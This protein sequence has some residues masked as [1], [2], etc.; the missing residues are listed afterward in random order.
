[1]FSVNGRLLTV[2]CAPIITGCIEPSR[3]VTE[4]GGATQDHHRNDPAT[5]PVP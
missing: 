1:M 5:V 3:T 4:A 2:L